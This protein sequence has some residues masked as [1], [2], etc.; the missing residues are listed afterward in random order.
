[1]ARERRGEAGGATDCS[2]SPRPG[3]CRR[4]ALR[5]DRVRYETGV[6]R[7]HSDG[8]MAF[9]RTE[10]GF[11]FGSKRF[12]RVEGLTG[13][14]LDARY[15]GSA[16]VSAGGGPA[17]AGSA[18]GFAATTYDFAADGTFVRSGSA[19]STASVPGAGGGTRGTRSGTRGTYAFEANTLVL[20]HEDGTE[21]RLL[22]RASG[23]GW[24]P[25]DGAPPILSIGGRLY[26]RR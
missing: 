21:E 16:S 23:D 17:D 25:G 15:E 22:V 10:D 3:N 13:L 2:A 26:E 18:A 6:E 19:V 14:R 4:Y 1:M 20:S 9:A 7:W 8:E 12:V 24:A 11:S 5:G